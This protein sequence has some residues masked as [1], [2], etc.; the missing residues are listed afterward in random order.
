MTADVKAVLAETEAIAIML[1]LPSA[2]LSR[3]S[4][5][6][7]YLQEVGDQDAIDF[8]REIRQSI[9]APAAQWLKDLGAGT[10]QPTREAT[11][12]R[13]VVAALEVV[14][15]I[16][17]ADALNECPVCIH[18]IEDGRYAYGGQKGWVAENFPCPTVESILAALGV[19]KE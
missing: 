14:I 1:N 17:E 12:V 7:G 15:A 5:M 16:H 10:L 9:K 13:S 11:L 18:T 2:D 3:L 6:D 8:W 4:E 19:G